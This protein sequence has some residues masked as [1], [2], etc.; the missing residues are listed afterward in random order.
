MNTEVTPGD[1]QGFSEPST[2]LGSFVL[3]VPKTQAFRFYQQLDKASFSLL[4][5][6]NSDLGDTE[7]YR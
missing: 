2:K 3:E 4:S 7:S 6:L 5:F 1:I